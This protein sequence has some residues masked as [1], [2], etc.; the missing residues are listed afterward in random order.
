[1]DLSSTAAEPAVKFHSDSTIQTYILAASRFGE[2]LEDVLSDIETGMLRPYSFPPLGIIL[3]KKSL[4][5][6]KVSKDL[7][8]PGPPL[9]LKICCSLWTVK[10]LL[11]S[12]AP[13]AA[14]KA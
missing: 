13:W 5:R 1:M 3:I 11:G 8:L 7:L 12:I 9:K 2:I 10:S 14:F 4:E 6:L